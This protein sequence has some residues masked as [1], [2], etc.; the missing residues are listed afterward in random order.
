VRRLERAT[1][2]KEG[3]VTDVDSLIDAL[4]LDRPLRVAGSATLREVAG[5]MDDADASCVLV[6]A[7]RGLVTEHDLAGALAAGL[8]P[9]SAVEQVATKAP[10]WATTA[11][12]L[13][14]AV[15]M[16]VEHGIRHLLVLSPQGEACGVL[17]LSTAMRVFLDVTTP[18]QAWPNR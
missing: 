7:N 15:T 1:S 16:M 4:P 11:T 13:L 3:T 10:V 2:H 14:D 12:T 17:S 6:G 8:S 18:L 5:M 9:D